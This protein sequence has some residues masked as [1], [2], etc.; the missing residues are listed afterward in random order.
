MVVQLLCRCRKA[1]HIYFTCF[2]W[3][4][5]KLYSTC[6]FFIKNIRN[7]NQQ[8]DLSLQK[9][10][11]KSLKRK[12]GGNRKIEKARGKITENKEALKMPF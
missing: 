2:I 7:R 8:R 12:M 11:G 1:V 9:E 4:E 5:N 10:E 3:N 6:F